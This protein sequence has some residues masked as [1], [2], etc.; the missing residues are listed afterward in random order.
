MTVLYVGLIALGLAD[1]LAPLIA[2]LIGGPVPPA[3]DLAQLSPIAAFLLSTWAYRAR[4][5]NRA[6]GRLLATAIARRG[7]RSRLDRA[8]WFVATACGVSALTCWLRFVATNAR[9]HQC[10][11]SRH[12]LPF[13]SPFGPPPAFAGDAVPRS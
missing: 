6:V 12:N 5:D 4:P 8:P 11:R 2:H 13:R 10:L 7:G 3:R 1:C 9:Q